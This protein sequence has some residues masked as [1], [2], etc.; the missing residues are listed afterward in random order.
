MFKLWTICRW[1]TLIYRTS[2][3]WCSIANCN[4]LPEGSGKFAQLCLVIR[5]LNVPLWW[6][7]GLRLYNADYRIS[8]SIHFV[9]IFDGFLVG[10]HEGENMD[11]SVAIL[12]QEH[13]G[14][15]LKRVSLGSRPS[16]HPHGTG[17]PDPLWGRG[18]R[19]DG[20]GL[21]LR[22]CRLLASP[23]RRG[24]ARAQLSSR[25]GRG[26]CSLLGRSG[27]LPRRARLRPL[28]RALQQLL[29]LLG[30]GC[31][32][33]PF[34]LP[35]TSCAP[36]SSPSFPRRPSALP[37]SRLATWAACAFTCPP[38]APPRPLRWPPGA[39]P[40]TACCI[41]PSRRQACS[42]A[43][44]SHCLLHTLHGPRG[45]WHA[46]CPQ[47]R[48]V[49]IFFCAPRACSAPPLTGTALRA[50]A[51]PFSSFLQRF[52]KRATQFQGLPGGKKKKNTKEKTPAKKKKKLAAAS[53][54]RCCRWG[55]RWLLRGASYCRLL[56]L[57]ADLQVPQLHIAVG[58]WE[59]SL[60]GS[61]LF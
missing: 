33:F 28:L 55:P 51:C 16:G 21:R 46:F 22:V 43:A 5:S 25:R 3:W 61:S 20:R 27:G 8:P 54:W 13:F 47:P 42:R 50:W 48:C 17:A 18:R 41:A 29:R 6:R 45:D 19:C 37:L 59:R 23:R 10:C 26:P 52:R 40:P 30:A 7:K 44:P 53:A 35:L 24:C 11:Q 60:F 58:G 1:F 2:Q 4:K 34:P 56:V 36:G 49:P 9:I 15:R 14:S 31:A 39:R 38:A 12:A 57:A 32:A